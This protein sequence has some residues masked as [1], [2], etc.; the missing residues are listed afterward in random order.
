MSAGTRRPSGLGPTAALWLTAGGLGLMRPAPGTWGSLPPAVLVCLMMGFGAPMWATAVALVTLCLVATWACIRWG[1]D[2]ERAFGAKDA[3]S[4]VID[5]VAGGAVAA[6][7]LAFIDGAG[8]VEA[9]VLSGIAFLLFRAFDI[10]KPGPI[11]LM[12]RWRSGLGVVA[13]DLAAGSLAGV[14]IMIFT[15]QALAL[16]ASLAAVVGGPSPS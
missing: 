12:Q 10:W 4:I 13:D 8:W 3:S 5:E 2:G 9:I 16:A 6:M 14:V 1:D 11:R 15:P 7:P